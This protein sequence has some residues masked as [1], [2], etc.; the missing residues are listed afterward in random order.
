MGQNHR[1]QF[2]TVSPK[3]FIYRIQLSHRRGS[4]NQP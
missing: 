4:V 3:L 2:S 1:N